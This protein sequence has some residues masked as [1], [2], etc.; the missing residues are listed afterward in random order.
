MQILFFD[1]I[2]TC[3]LSHTF[4]TDGL[5]FE[6]L[7]YESMLNHNILPDHIGSLRSLTMNDKYA[8]KFRTPIEEHKEARH[9]GKYLQPAA[10]DLP[11]SKGYHF[12]DER[13][14]ELTKQFE[15]LLRTSGKARN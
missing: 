13:E 6:V 5:C 1:W 9:K 14:T 8:Q 7:M 4:L 11:F 12:Q 15:G 2:P 10:F 3:D